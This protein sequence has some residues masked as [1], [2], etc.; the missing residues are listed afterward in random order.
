MQHPGAASTEAGVH[1]D[2]A[3]ATVTTAA[4]RW[5]VMARAVPSKQARAALPLVGPASVWGGP[6]AAPP[7][8]W[9][10]GSIPHHTAQLSHVARHVRPGSCMLAA[11]GSG[12]GGNGAAVRGSWL[13]VRSA[14]VPVARVARVL[15]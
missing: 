1:M 8:L 11:G 4:R 7:Q 12:H 2:S 9:R 10:H 13:R 3:V 14:N 6:A 15:A 5:Q